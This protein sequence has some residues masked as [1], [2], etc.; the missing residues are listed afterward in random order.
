LAAVRFVLNSPSRRHLARSLTN[1]LAPSLNL[2]A[3][4]ELKT[5]LNTPPGT[6]ILAYYDRWVHANL[7][8]TNRCCKKHKKVSERCDK[9]HREAL[10][11][12]HN[13]NTDICGKDRPPSVKKKGKK[14]RK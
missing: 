14:G 12:F 7:P 10:I 1:Q 2:Q 13:E 8:S 5:V 4:V 9:G 6:M 11:L 3:F